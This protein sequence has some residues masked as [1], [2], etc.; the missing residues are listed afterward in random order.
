VLLAA[1]TVLRTLVGAI[2][3]ILDFVNSL[4]R[5]FGNG[6]STGKFGQFFTFLYNALDILKTVVFLVLALF[7]LK[8][9]TINIGFVDKFVEKHLSL[10]K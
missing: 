9:K 2:P 10:E 3:T 1:F 4:V 8:M 6:F 5:V 7:A